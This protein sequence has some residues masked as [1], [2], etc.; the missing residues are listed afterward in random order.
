[1]KKRG[2]K[3]YKKK[4]KRIFLPY[5]I[6]IFLI[7]SYEIVLGQEMI[8]SGSLFLGNIMVILGVI[9]TAYFFF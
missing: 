4:I 7:P 6:L 5:I 2:K 9:A 8:K 3:Y 1:M